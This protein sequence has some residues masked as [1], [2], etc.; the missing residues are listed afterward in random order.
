MMKN[1]K[2]SKPYSQNPSI[3]AVRDVMVSLQKSENIEN[4]ASQCSMDDIMDM[5]DG[6][7]QK[8]LFIGSLQYIF[9][10][11][12]PDVIADEIYALSHP[13]MLQREK[14]LIKKLL[15]FLTLLPKAKER[16]NQ[17]EILDLHHEILLTLGDA[18]ITHCIANGV[19]RQ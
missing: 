7:G 5:L 11:K 3:H 6:D 19:V 13:E 2:Q 9:N 16:N 14:Y 15:N 12:N 8:T 4:F 10:H 18:C 1:N 17:D